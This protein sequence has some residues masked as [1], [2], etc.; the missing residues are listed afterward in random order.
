MLP[1][2]ASEIVFVLWRCTLVTAQEAGEALQALCN[3]T[4]AAQGLEFGAGSLDAASDALGMQPH[5]KQV[6]P[7]AVECRHSMWLVPKGLCQ[8]MPITQLI[9]AKHIVMQVT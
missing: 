1:V 9:Q 5:S 4:V 3:N 6:S 2:L 7:G 8:R